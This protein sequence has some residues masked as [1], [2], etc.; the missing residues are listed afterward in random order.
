MAPEPTA[1]GSRLYIFPHTGGS[2]DFYVPFA[3]SFTGGTKCVAVQY[4]GKRAGK[5]LSKYTAIP[6]MADRLCAMLKPEQAPA[7]NVAFFGHSMGAL[8]AF[9]VALRF[10]Q[11][12]NPISA[13]FVSASA[14]PGLL[15]RIA[16]LQGSDAHLLSMISTVTGANPEFLNDEQFAATILP[17]LRGLKAVTAY[18]SPPEAKVS[19]PIHA[20]MA[21]NDELGTEELMR[22]WEQ[23]TTASFDLTVFHG[24]HFYMTTNLPELA[25][26]VEERVRAGSARG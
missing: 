1:A 23:R 12:G 2:A 11:A 17:T 18:E 21:D 24:D 10:E 13:L 6:E 4:P 8:L 7:D 16:N 20:L 15:R 3:R 14:A 9:E 22:P 5:D 19:C 25:H 26:W